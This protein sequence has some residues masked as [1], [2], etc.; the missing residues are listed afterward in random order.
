M[1]MSY[2]FMRLLISSR[3]ISKTAITLIDSVVIFSVLGKF[4]HD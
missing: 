3:A 4:E 1:W 2:L